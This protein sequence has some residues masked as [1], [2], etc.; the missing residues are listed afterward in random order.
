MVDEC[1]EYLGQRKQAKMQWLQDPH[2]RNVDSLNNIRLESFRH[3]RYIKREDLK[4]KVD[5]IQIN[6]EKTNMTDLYS[7]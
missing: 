4:A 6:C 7:N 1:V 2:Q 3:F 5:E